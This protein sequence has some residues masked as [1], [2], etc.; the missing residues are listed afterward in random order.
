MSNKRRNGKRNKKGKYRRRKYGKRRSMFAKAPATPLGQTFK[1][2]TRYYEKALSINPGASGAAASYV[3]S[4]NGLYDPNVTGVGH[5]PIGFDQLMQMYDHY[6]VIASRIKVLCHNSSAT[7]KVIWGIYV[8]DEATA[9]LDPSVIIENGLGKHSYLLEEGGNPSSAKY[10]TLGHSVKKFF[11]KKPLQDPNLQGTV[12]ANPAEQ[13]YFHIWA[14]DLSNADPGAL[15]LCVE[16][17]YVAILTE[18]QQLS[19]S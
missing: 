5:Q 12:S 7:S 1:Y 14:A 2:K 16:I 10:M 18:P 9:E 4:A 8:K 11:N 17:E 19:L 3:F 15:D 13:S 6:T